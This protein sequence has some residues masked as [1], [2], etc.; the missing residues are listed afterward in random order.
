MIV[1]RRGFLQIFAAAPAAIIASKASA[2]WVPEQSTIEIDVPEI[3]VVRELVSAG[4]MI[5]GYFLNKLTEGSM[6][7]LMRDSTYHFSP[8]VQI[9]ILR[10]N[11][12]KVYGFKRFMFRG[13]QDALL[14]GER[15]EILSTWENGVAKY[16]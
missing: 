15:Y 3:E 2:I 6:E 11:K 12:P 7:L 10:N 5:G 4:E 8:G 13:S 1:S 14:S 16:A 9:I